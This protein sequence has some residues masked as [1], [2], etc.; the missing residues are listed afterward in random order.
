L[1][2]KVD[3]IATGH[4]LTDGFIFVLNNLIKGDILLLTKYNIILP[5]KDG[6]IP[7]IKPLFFVYEKEAALYA[8][9]AGLNPVQSTCPYSKDAPTLKMKNTALTMEEVQPGSI[10]QFMKSFLRRLLP[11]LRKVNELTTL[12]SCIKC[13]LPSSQKIC[14]FCKLKINIREKM[15]ESVF[16]E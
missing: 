2:F 1:E 4:N 13:G 10:L 14:S 7:R 8:H 5:K 12:Q 11:N 3:C 6:L 16:H 9:Y 15:A